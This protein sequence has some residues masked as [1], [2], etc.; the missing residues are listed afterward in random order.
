MKGRREGWRRGWRVGPYREHARAR[1]RKYETGR[2]IGLS[3]LLCDR[4]ATLLF[5]ELSFMIE[6]HYT[7]IVRV[8]R[9]TRLSAP[10]IVPNLFN[11]PVSALPWRVTLFDSTCT[12][13][14]IFSSRPPVKHSMA[15]REFRDDRTVSSRSSSRTNFRDWPPFPRNRD[16]D[17]LL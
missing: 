8:I 14:I 11:L 17:T 4:A 12:L 13:I 2:V 16:F 10:T 6:N 15:R 3:A 5:I 7:L 1:V 9:F